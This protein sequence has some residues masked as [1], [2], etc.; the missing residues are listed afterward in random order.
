MAPPTQ[1]LR[2]R[3]QAFLDEAIAAGRDVELQWCEGSGHN[4]PGMPVAV[5]RDAFG[6][7]VSDFFT[8]TLT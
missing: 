8:R 3:T 4:A 1:D 7:W 6:R 2:E 5:C